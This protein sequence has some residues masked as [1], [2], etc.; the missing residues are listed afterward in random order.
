M[1]III[2]INK[3]GLERCAGEVIADIL[4]MIEND[5]PDDVLIQLVTVG[6]ISIIIVIIITFFMR[7]FYYSLLLFVII[8]IHLIYYYFSFCV[9]IIILY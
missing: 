5:D 1:I 6:F 2:L 7:D 4:E 8:V 3:K 9:N